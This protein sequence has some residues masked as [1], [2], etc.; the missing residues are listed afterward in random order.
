LGLCKNNLK[1]S[2]EK[3][4]LLPQVRTSSKSII[5]STFAL[6]LRSFIKYD[7]NNLITF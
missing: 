7:S 5:A 6:I 1:A 2:V 3:L 4:F